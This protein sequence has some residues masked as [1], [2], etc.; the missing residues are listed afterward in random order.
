[1]NETR[2]I[3]GA[4]QDQS[5]YSNVLYQLCH[6]KGIESNLQKVMNAHCYNPEAKPLKKKP[7]RREHCVLAI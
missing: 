2:I 7:L 1:M 5:L 6:P 4:T 3:Y